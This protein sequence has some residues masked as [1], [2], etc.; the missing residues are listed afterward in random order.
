MS[1]LG[2]VDEQLMSSGELVLA[3]RT[4]HFP[5]VP[6]PPGTPELLSKHLTDYPRPTP[7]H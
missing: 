6:S 3:H 1:I 5:E 4:D 7:K 2:K